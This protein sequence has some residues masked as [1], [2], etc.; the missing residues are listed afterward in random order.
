M[1]QTVQHAATTFSC[2]GC[3]G[4]PVWDPASSK[5]KCPFCGTMSDVEQDYTA[6]EEYDMDTAPEQIRGAWGET[7]RVVRCQGCGAETILGPAETATFCAFCGSPHVLEDQSEAGIAPES[8]LPF[9]ITEKAAVSAF[10]SWLKRKLFAPGKVKKMAELG[11]ISGVYLPHWTYDSDTASTYTGQ[12]GHYYYVNVPVTVERNGKRVTEMR[13]ERR[14]RWEP[15]AGQVEHHFNDVVV[16]GSQRLEENLLET[17]QPY[18]LDALCRYQAGF[19][20]GF[21][22]EKPSVDVHTGW[23]GAQQRIDST[24]RQLAAEDILTHADEANVS[25]LQ[26][27]HRDVRYKLTL[28]PMYLS[29]FPYKGKPYHVLING[30]NG[31]CGGETPVSPWRVLAAVLLTAALLAGGYYLL[32]YTGMLS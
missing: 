24:M 29:S 32:E 1:T 14:I 30:Q 31:R 23:I 7:K 18:D 20:S 5:M 13:R 25:E 3:G 10:R 27:R 15:T 4:R 26:S 12:A 16:P 19:L 2:P 22:A 11:K 17:V 21:Q 28:L 6:P 8:I 9:R